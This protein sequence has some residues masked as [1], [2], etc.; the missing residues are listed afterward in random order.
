MLNYPIQEQPIFQDIDNTIPLISDETGEQV[1]KYII[2]NPE[3]GS[4][5]KVKM[6][7]APAKSNVASVSDVW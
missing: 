5:V 3:G 4:R 6:P 1:V 2:S 7:V